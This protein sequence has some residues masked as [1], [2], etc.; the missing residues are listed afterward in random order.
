[1]HVIGMIIIFK[2]AE[3]LIYTAVIGCLGGYIS[4]NQVFS[5]TILVINVSWLFISFIF[6]T[7]FLLPCT[8]FVLACLYAWW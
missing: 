5:Y 6:F 3:P 2:V 4:S 7:Y 1:M 8:F